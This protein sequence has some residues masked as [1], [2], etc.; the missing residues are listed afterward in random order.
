MKKIVT[1]IVFGTVFSVLL[2]GCAGERAEESFSFENPGGMWMPGQLA[3]Q[4]ETLE[5]LGVENPEKF[6]DLESYPLGAIVWLGG[7][8]A[9]FVSPDGLIITNHHCVRSMLQYNSTPENNYLE[10]GFYAS[11][12]EDEIS[13]G[14]GR[15]VWVARDII[16]VTEKVR[17]GVE[18]IDDPK[19]RHDEIQRRITRIINNCDDPEQGI[20]CRVRSFFGGEKYYLFKQF[21][22]KDVRLVYAPA[23]SVG[24]YGGAVDNW[25]WPRHTGDFSFLRAYVG[26]DGESA[27]YSED[28]V[29]YKPE[30]HLRVA[31]E[32]LSE[33]DFVM[34]AGYPGWTNR[35]STAGEMRRAVQKVFPWRIKTLKEVL[36]VL[37]ELAEV[38]EEL[39]IKV[40]GSIF[41][42]KNY[43][44]LTEGI[45]ASIAK[46][47][48]LEEKLMKQAKMEAWIDADAD[49]RAKWGDTVE[50]LAAVNHAYSETLLRDMAVGDLMGR[51]DMVDSAYT[52]LRMAE[53]QEKPDEE[54]DSKFQERNWERLI[55]GTK[56]MQKN[57]DRRIDKALMKFY[58]GK[59]MELEDDDAEP[60]MRALFG[61]AEISLAEAAEAVE[62][63]YSGEIEIEDPEV[64]VDLLKNA[65]VADLK[66][67]DDPFIKLALRIRPLLKIKQEKDEAYDGIMAVLRPEYI[68]AFKAWEDE[69]V[70]P[71]ANGTLRVTYGTI[72]GYRPEPDAPMY[73]PFTKLSGVVAKN[74]GEDPFDSPEELLDAAKAEKY[75]PY[76]NPALGEVSVNYISDLDITGGNSGSATLN[77][78]GELIGLVFDGNHESVG[79][80]WVFMP[81]V[82]RAIHVDID[83]ALWIM[84][85][86][87]QAYRVIEELGVE[88]ATK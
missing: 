42:T 50:E 37:E 86:V 45:A 74:T 25:H 61:D 70:A 58:V 26:P 16:D 85:Y 83:Y 76:V 31:D 21:E 65:T 13:G 12:L 40:N 88:P 22:I 82:T 66:K 17:S 49:R 64:R 53:E 73:E 46:A 34:V 56:R 48:L 54:R 20:R 39:A 24:Y 60:V 23:M 33:G 27:E 43:L 59:V 67:M 71:D 51:V 81:D 2:M 87:D 77:N 5:K 68:K 28:N 1:L 30:Y 75:G 52:I 38:D 32:P 14:P 63:L 3:E 7:C 47:D 69:P 6:T 84:D 4:K 10:N 55:Q 79:S 78:K 57:Y 44:Q 72:R 29:P 80:N 35:L 41:G 11:S 19:E 18:K 62:E 8:S 9:S 36:V 15:H